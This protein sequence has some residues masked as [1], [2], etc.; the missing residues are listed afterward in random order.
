MCVCVSILSIVYTVYCV[1]GPTHVGYPTFQTSF[2][3]NWP[4]VMVWRLLRHFLRWQ[5]A[6][7]NPSRNFCCVVS[8][9]ITLLLVRSKSATA[10]RSAI[11][12]KTSFIQWGPMMPSGSIY[13]ELHGNITHTQTHTRITHTLAGE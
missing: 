2:N 11:L 3:C 9:T 5:L 13:D 4:V 6:A 8:L 1:M 10:N 7:E 12:A